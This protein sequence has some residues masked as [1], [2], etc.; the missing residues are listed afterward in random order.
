MIE[1][2]K[3]SRFKPESILFDY[4]Q[5]PFINHIILL[6][7]RLK[8]MHFNILMMNYTDFTKNLKISDFLIIEYWLLYETIGKCN[9]LKSENMIF[10]DQIDILNL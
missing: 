1:L 7:E 10:F 6:Y 8:K 9:L 2:Y 4:K 5:Y 3:K